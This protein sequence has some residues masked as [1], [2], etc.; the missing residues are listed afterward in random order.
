MG[1]CFAQPAIPY[2]VKIYICMKRVRKKTEFSVWLDRPKMPVLSEL[3][4]L[5]LISEVTAASM[6]ATSAAD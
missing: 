4:D 3:A 2:S 6:R 5:A 1:R